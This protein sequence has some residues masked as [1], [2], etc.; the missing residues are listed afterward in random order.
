MKNTK[1]VVYPKLEIGR[2]VDWNKHQRAKF[3]DQADE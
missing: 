1:P 3:W 2:G